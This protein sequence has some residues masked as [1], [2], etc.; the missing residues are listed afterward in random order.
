MT[1]AELIEALKDYPDD[2]CIEI[3]HG[4]GG[5][6]YDI[7]KVVHYNDYGIQIAE[8]AIS[9]PKTVPESIIRGIREA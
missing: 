9:E 5:N 8:L 1:K 7:G 3:V 4:S 6:H 2:A